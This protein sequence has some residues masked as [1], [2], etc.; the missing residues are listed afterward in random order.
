MRKRIVDP[1][2]VNT[3]INADKH[4]I[5]KKFDH[6]GS[7]ALLRVISAEDPDKTKD[8]VMNSLLT[9]RNMWIFNE[10]PNNKKENK[11]L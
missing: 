1:I 6:L 8:E 2:Y 11:G 4:L 7:V 9:L 3:K 5:R 10:K